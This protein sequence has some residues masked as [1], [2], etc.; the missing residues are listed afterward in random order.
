ME[1]GQYQKIATAAGYFE[2]YAHTVTLSCF[3]WKFESV[4]FF[5][6]RADFSRDV[7]GRAGWLQHLRLGLVNHDSRLYLSHYDD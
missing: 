7:V 1:S 6:A 5:A 2:A 3:D 4:V